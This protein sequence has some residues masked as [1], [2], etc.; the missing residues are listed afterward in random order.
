MN[1]VTWEV[2]YH[3]L[4]KT[5]RFCTKCGTKTEFVSSGLFRVNAQHK[6]LDI[7]LVYRCARCK[8]TWNLTILSRVNPKSVGGELLERFM[9]ND[10][11]L[12]ERYATDTDLLARNGA[13]TEP[14]AYAVRGEDIRLSG[15]TR[16]VIL[17][18]YPSKLR[19]GKLVREKL[20]LPRKTFNALVSDG[21]IRMENG[22]DIEKAKLQ[23]EAVVLIGCAAHAGEKE[24]DA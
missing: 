18:P 19:V 2:K 5:T 23:R 13:E 8:T 11:A 1:T 14:P 16:I 24:Q 22:A 12:A 20:N 21:V 6:Y 7:W 17:S 15:Q 3:S 10:G 9:N 4:P